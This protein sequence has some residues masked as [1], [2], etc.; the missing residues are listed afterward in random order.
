MNTTKPEKGLF[1][2]NKVFLFLELANIPDKTIYQR[3]G[4]MTFREKPYAG[5]AWPFTASIE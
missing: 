1:K 2:L 5:Q 3:V 4:T